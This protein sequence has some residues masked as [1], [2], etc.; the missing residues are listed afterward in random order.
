MQKLGR[1]TA[2]FNGIISEK[3]NL[4]KIT[5]IVKDTWADLNVKA[6]VLSLPI[7]RNGA[8]VIKNEE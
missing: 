8:T 3:N 1:I 5:S 7:E 2:V 6:E 4:D